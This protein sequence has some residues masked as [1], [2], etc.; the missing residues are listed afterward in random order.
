MRP[1]P[2]GGSESGADWIQEN[3]PRDFAGRQ[4]IA[5]QMVVIPFLPEVADSQPASRDSCPALERF[6]KY[7]QVAGLRSCVSEEVQV[8]EHKTV[9]GNRKVMDRAG[10]PK[11]GKAC[12]NQCVVCEQFLSAASA[13]R[14]EV[15]LEAEVGSRPKAVGRVEN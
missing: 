15:F 11:D 7:R 13:E 12:V 8:I 9:S 3:G 2:D 10:L 6:H 14:K 4:R 5:D 1:F